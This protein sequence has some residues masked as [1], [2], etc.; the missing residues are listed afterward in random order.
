MQNSFYDDPLVSNV[1]AELPGIDSRLKNEVVMI[2]A[3][4]DSW[5][6]GTGATD[7]GAGSAVMMEAMR[8]LSTLQ[9]HPR[10]SIR[11]ALWTG[12]EQNAMGSMAYVKQ[13]FQGPAKSER[14][15]FSV[16][17]NL[18]GGTGKIRGIFNAQ[19]A[20]VRPIFDAWMGP[21]KDQ[22]MKTVSPCDVGGA[23]QLSFERIGLPSFGFIQD[24]IEYDTRTHHT[25]ADVYE[26]IQ[27]EDMKFNA[28]V[29]ASFAWQAAQRN[30]KLP[31]SAPP[32]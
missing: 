10:R 16:Y 4:L 27:P 32:P 3:H 20:T 25:S 9:L 2:G 24:P 23:D 17:F 13:H 30:E 14:D 26:R 31:R 29:L 12:E 6:F 5:T 7:D 22:G 1:I 15:A 18:D 19:N 8:I 28:A 21:F 11:V